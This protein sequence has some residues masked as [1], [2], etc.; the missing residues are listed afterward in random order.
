MERQVVPR[1]LVT[2]LSDSS[3][4]QLQL[5]RLARLTPC[6]GCSHAHAGSYARLA[7]IMAAAM[8]ALT[9]STSGNWIALAPHPKSGSRSSTH[10][11]RSC[12]SMQACHITTSM[13]GRTWSSC[14]AS[15]PQ[16]RQ[17]WRYHSYGSLQICRR[18]TA[19]K[20]CKTPTPPREAVYT[21][22]W[23]WTVV[24]N[25]AQVV[26]VEL[27]AL[28]DGS[29]PSHEFNKRLVFLELRALATGC[30]VHVFH[31]MVVRETWAAAGNFEYLPL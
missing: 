29:F 12:V 30:F 20:H 28:R 22:W 11:A 14:A 19:V 27:Q 8:Q 24:A 9:S 15:Q 2:R 10:C 31:A 23:R 21:G 13:T 16:P 4:P 17:P 26:G 1:R 3:Q 18:C 5:T 7:I 25:L 6:T